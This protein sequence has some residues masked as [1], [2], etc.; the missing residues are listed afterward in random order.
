MS[1]TVG[2]IPPRYDIS[3]VYSQAFRHVRPPFP[4]LVAESKTLG[5]SP[6]GTIRGLGGSLK[7]T[8]VLGTPIT[9]DTKLDGWQM[10][11][12]PT[13]E[14]RGGKNI[15]E[16]Q[17]NRG[18]R[19]ANVLEEINLNNYQIRIRGVILNEEEFDLYPEVDVRR[20]MEICEKPG[21]VSI[22]NQI[23]TIFNIFQVAIRDFNFFEVKGYAGAQAYELDL[24]SD[25][26]ISLEGIDRPE[27][28]SSLT[29]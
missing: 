13:I 12:E 9:L 19:K 26:D 20:L 10:P 21:S 7:L 3:Q 25:E 11:N 16:T 18:E 6:V 4:V 15:I 23:C 8:S 28:R 22:N 24:L 1:E 17:L 29:I 2:T 14:I 5:I 27:V